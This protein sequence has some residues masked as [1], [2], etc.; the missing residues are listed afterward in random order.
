[1]ASHINKKTLETS[2]GY[3]KKIMPHAMFQDNVMPGKQRTIFI[4]YLGPHK[5][6]IL[7]IENNSKC[8]VNE[9]KNKSVTNLTSV[10]L[11]RGLSSA[12]FIH[13]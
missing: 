12:L 13:K 5:A 9:I 6:Q 7:T 8:R 4:L 11:S 10:L 3:F 1:M 2:L